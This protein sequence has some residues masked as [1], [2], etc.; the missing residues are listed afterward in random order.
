MKTSISSKLA[1]LWLLAVPVVARGQSAADLKSEIALLEQHIG[2]ARGS[3]DPLVQPWLSLSDIETGIAARPLAVYLDHFATLSEALRTTSVG[4]TR[5]G[6]LDGF[7]AN[8]DICVPIFGCHTYSDEWWWIAFEENAGNGSL[9]LSGTGAV[10]NPATGQLSVSTGVDARVKVGGWDWE[11]KFC[12]GGPIK[13]HLQPLS[14]HA[15]GGVRATLNPLS[16]DEHGLSYALVVGSP[17]F[18]AGCE[19]E[20]NVLGFFFTARMDTTLPP[21]TNT[22]SGQVD[23]PFETSGALD[24]SGPIKPPKT[25]YRLALVGPSIGTTVRGYKAV[26]KVHVEWLP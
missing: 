13:G 20:V 17:G 12:L 7:G 26:A 24:S 11:R 21:I 3:L 2:V 1:I 15:N 14:C 25:R 23:I 6:N 5:E 9:V 22:L 19:I 8:C 4:L 18:G 10:W 16:F